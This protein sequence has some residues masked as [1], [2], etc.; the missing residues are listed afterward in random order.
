MNEHDAYVASD[1]TVLTDDLVDELA[2]EAENGFA[3]SIL[4]PVEGRPWQAETEP[5]RRAPSA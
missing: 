3:N 4:T 1:G 2:A 5:L